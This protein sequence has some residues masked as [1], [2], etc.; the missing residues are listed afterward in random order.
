MHRGMV[1]GWR[2]FR[3]IEC[4]ERTRV[5]QQK[6]KRRAEIEQWHAGERETFPRCGRAL[7]FGRRASPDAEMEAS[8]LVNRNPYKSVRYFLWQRKRFEAA[9]LKDRIGSCDCRIF[10][11]HCREKKF[12]FFSTLFIFW[13]HWISFDKIYYRYEI[14]FFLIR[15]FL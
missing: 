13:N 11:I 1:E 4:N 15:I 9:L 6:L 12:F 2:A 5:D 10:P 7:R 14:D 3:G 8:L